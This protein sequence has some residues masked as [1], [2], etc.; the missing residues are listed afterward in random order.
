MALYQL[1]QRD[2]E[3]IIDFAKSREANEQQNESLF[4]FES[5]KNV[6]V[7]VS[8]IIYHY[9][10]MSE[11]ELILTLSALCKQEYLPIDFVVE[12]IIM[13]DGI[14]LKDLVLLGDIISN[15]QDIVIVDSNTNFVGPGLMWNVG[16]YISRGKKI[17]FTWTGVYWLKDSLFR[18]NNI[19]E[20]EGFDGAYGQVKFEITKELNHVGQFEANPAWV[21]GANMIPLCYCLLSRGLV[22]K[23]KGFYADI[24][25]CRIVDWEFMLR[26]SA[27]SRL[28]AFDAAPIIGRVALCNVHSNLKFK[29]SMDE[30]IRFG[31]NESIMFSYKK[32]IT[33]KVLNQSFSKKIRAAKERENKLYKIGIIS[34]L[35]ERSQIQFS[36]L[37]FFEKLSKIISWRKFNESTLKIS[38]LKNYDLIFFVRSRTEQAVK[39]AQYCFKKDIMTAYILDDNWISDT[40]IYPQQENHIEMDTSFYDNFILLIS[41]M[42]YVVIYNDLLWQGVRDYNN[43]VILFPV[44]INLDYFKRRKKKNN[45]TNIRIGYTDRNFELQYFDP[46]FKAVERIMDKYKEVNLYLKGVELPVAFNKYGNRVSLSAYEPDY[47][48]YCKDIAEAYCDIML[49]PLENNKYNKSKCQ[50]MYLE[51]TA[52]GAVGIYTDHESNKEFIINEYNGLMIENEEEKWFL[53]IERLIV[54]D[55]LRIDLLSN[56]R[57]DINFSYNTNVA[58]PRFKQLLKMMLTKETCDKP[59]PINWN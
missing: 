54:D 42:D 44:N 17:C 40:E 3:F 6:D 2:H 5:N 47:L 51:S 34:D 49:C 10:D 19:I 50:N 30:I 56:S 53:A 24:A 52:A 25:L 59:N 32:R 9:K 7:D 45:P 57:K 58:L 23:L 20:D 4:W 8:F 15:R 37:G 16:S 28:K 1:V 39:A 33:K 22:E 38:E 27:I 43:Q 13:L 21:Q 36:L 26:V 31:L 46:I 29:E 14:R 11:V 41:T 48:K 18:L 35:N 55:K 12:I